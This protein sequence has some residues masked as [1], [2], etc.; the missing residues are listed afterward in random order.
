MLAAADRDSYDASMRIWPLLVLLSS[1]ALADDDEPPRPR[2][3]QALSIRFADRDVDDVSTSFDGIAVSIG[4]RFGAYTLYA[5][6]ELG[7]QHRKELE[8]L[9]AGAAMHVRRRICGFE[10]IERRDEMALP[11]WVELGVGWSTLLSRDVTVNRPVISLGVG[12]GVEAATR[13]LRG[14]LTLGI[15]VELAPVTTA[16][17][18]LA[19]SA[20]RT[21]DSTTNRV[22]AGVRFDITFPFGR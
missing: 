11:C 1:P 12:G 14:G 3:F 13:K 5:A 17:R 8:G 15:A 22:D 19:P 20:E 6:G 18:Q 4:R 21:T 9:A 2:S 10:I 16:A 7:Y